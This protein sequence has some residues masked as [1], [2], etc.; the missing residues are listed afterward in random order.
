V[1]AGIVESEFSHLLGA[2]ARDNGGIGA[3]V[4]DTTGLKVGAAGLELEGLVLPADRLATLRKAPDD[5]PVEVHYTCE[6]L[7]ELTKT[8]I[9]NVLHG[10]PCYPLAQ[11]AKDCK[12]SVTVYYRPVIDYQ[13]DMR[14]LGFSMFI[15]RDKPPCKDLRRP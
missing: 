13:R 15:V 3:A 4:F 12:A 11:F 5:P 9:Q 8:C 7:R 14:G 2:I 10:P 6:K 1:P